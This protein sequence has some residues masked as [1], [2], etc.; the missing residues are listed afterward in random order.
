MK[1]F[2]LSLIVIL[3]LFSLICHNSDAL[4]QAKAISFSRCRLQRKTSL[5]FM[6][7]I[8]DEVN[9][10]HISI[11]ED[12]DNDNLE[13]LLDKLKGLSMDEISTDTRSSIENEIR[14]NSPSDT[15]IRLGLMGFTPLTYAG[16]LLAAVIIFFNN[17]LGNGWAGDMIGLNSGGMEIS[18]DDES[19]GRMK[20]FQGDTIVD[21]E[22]IDRRLSSDSK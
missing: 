11:L 8:K 7:A 2:P 15:Q 9:D 1:F 10:E 19:E 21:Y 16:Y 14:A 12:L 13:S 20:E 5:L 4:Q 18:R 17:V 3:L 6:N 22:D